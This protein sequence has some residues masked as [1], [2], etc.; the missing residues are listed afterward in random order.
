MIFRGGLNKPFRIF[1]YCCI[2]QLGVDL[3]SAQLASESKNTLLI[4]N[5]WHLG[6]F[7]F[8]SLMFRH[9]FINERVNKGIL[10]ATYLFVI[11]F[12]IDILGSNDNLFDLHYH[13]YTLIVPVL[14]SFIILLLCLLY[15]LELFQ[16]LY[17]DD[18]MQ[19]EIFW[20]ISGLLI[21]S[22]SSVFANSINN[23]YLQWRNDQT[24]LIIIYIPYIAYSFS[25]ILTSIGLIVTKD[26]PTK[27]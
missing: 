13:K 14:G 8:M 4:C 20:L 18:L 27:D 15:F 19:S 21:Y 5:L 10:Y 2:A 9:I 16:E 22:A 1:L 6:N 23:W 7:I 17:I 11:V 25:V 12:I 26:K 24:Y 3:I